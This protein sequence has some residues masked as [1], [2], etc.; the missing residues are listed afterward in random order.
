MKLAIKLALLALLSGCVSPYQATVDDYITAYPNINLGMS[1]LEVQAILN[2]SQSRL[3][4][5]EIKQSDRYMKEGVVV[6]ILYFRSG[7]N[8]QHGWKIA[9][10]AWRWVESFF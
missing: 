1:K 3:S 9:Q 7:W 4:N 8:S 10:S 6:E 2:P 5:T